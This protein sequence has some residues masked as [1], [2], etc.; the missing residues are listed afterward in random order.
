MIEQ[1]WIGKTSIS[2]RATQLA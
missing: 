2:L 1:I